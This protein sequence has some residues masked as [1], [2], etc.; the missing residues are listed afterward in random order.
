MRQAGFEVKV[1]IEIDHYSAITY[2]LNHPSSIMIEKDIKEVD[3]SII[4][5]MI[6]DE[7]IQLLA[8]CPPCQGFSSIRRLNKSSV[9]DDRN[10]LIMDYLK[11]V[12]DLR[13]MTIMLENV[14]RLIKYSLFSMVIK[15]L[16][17][18]GYYI[19]V[20]IVNVKDYGVPQRRIRLVLI[21]SRLGKIKVAEP[22]YERKTV[23]DAIGNLESIY[24]T[25]DPLHKIIAKHSNKVQKMISMVSKNGGSRRD[26]PIEYILDCHM[27]PNIGFYDVYGRLKWEL[28]SSTITGGCLNPSKGRFLHPSEDRVITPREA[29]LLQTFP[30]DYIFPLEIPKHDLARIIGEALPPKFS[31]IQCENI[32]SHLDNYYVGHI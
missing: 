22:T 16:N 13:P 12:A 5:K 15:I 4:K 19:S 8:G 26:L 29:S 31:R 9:Y 21:G 30:Q 20:K 3:T 18:L 32:K 6:G 10:S 17:T 27:K 28:P 2:S 25:K 23:K 11:F 1:A 14:P 7:E 24:K